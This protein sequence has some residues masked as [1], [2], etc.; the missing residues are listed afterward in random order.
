MRQIIAL[1]IT[2]VILGAAL[3]NIYLAD[4]MDELYID[5]EKLKVELYETKERLKKTEDQW[6]IHRTLVI[7][8]IEVEF[9]Q[10]ERDS[11]TEIRLREAVARLTQS[12][13]GEDLEKI[14]HTLVVHLLDQ[15]IVEVEGKQYRLQVKTVVIAEKITYVLHYVHQ[16]AEGD[17]EP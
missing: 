1:V 13:I 7:R 6:Q 5:R 9:L 10:Q 17:G 14:P 3:M 8:E 2:G 4:K 11:F 16:I 12:L 15:R